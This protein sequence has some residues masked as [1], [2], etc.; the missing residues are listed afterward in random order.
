MQPPCQNPAETQRKASKYLE[1]QPAKHKI[2]RELQR[3]KET[4][5]VLAKKP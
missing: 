3:Q 4:E 2:K 1:Q 5:Y